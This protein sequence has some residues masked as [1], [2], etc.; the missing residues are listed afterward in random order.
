MS[1]ETDPVP[2]VPQHTPPINERDNLKRFENNWMQWFLLLRDKI[3]IINALIVNF[4]G[5]T[6][7]G[8]LV[9][10]NSIN[11]FTRSLVQG[12]GISLTNADG[13]AGDPTIAHG[14]TSSVSDLTSNNS[15]TT[16]LQDFSIAF[17]TFG[18]VQSVSVGTVDITTVLPTLDHGTY[19]P[20]LTNV[21]NVTSSTASVCQYLRVGDSVTVSGRIDATPTAGGGT[22]SRVDISLPIASNFTLAAQCAGAGSFSQSTGITSAQIIGDTTNDRAIFQ[23]NSNVT[24]ST[25]G[26][27]TFTY[28]IV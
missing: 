9:L 13:T 7:N 18:H 28:R 1:S 22:L 23:F 10:Q 17:D 8:F 12:A 5:I 24:A 3:N 27:F 15:G 26:L 11:W 14:D 6:G 2:P 25:A 16:V 19:T 4:S 20:T 21:T